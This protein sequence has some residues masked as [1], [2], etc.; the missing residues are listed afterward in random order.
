MNEF[1]PVASNHC[2]RNVGFLNLLKLK[3]DFAAGLHG[4]HE[5]SVRIYQRPMRIGGVWGQRVPYGSSGPDDPSGQYTAVL[6]P[7]GGIEYSVHV[8]VR[9]AR[10]N[11]DALVRFVLRAQQVGI[12]VA[13]AFSA[14]GR[15]IHTV[16]RGNAFWQRLVHSGHD[17][18]YRRISQ[19]LRES[20]LEP[21][22][23]RFIKL[24]GGWA[25]SKKKKQ[26][27][28]DPQE[29]RRQISVMSVGP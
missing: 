8:I 29:K 22:N 7:I 17:G 19:G 14:R 23:L 20:L 27:P 15:F 13:P 25:F 1:V 9:M 24:I 10:K 2:L 16:T 3:I 26:T 12:H 11:V 6:L 21:A 5:R 18:R 28:L 4:P